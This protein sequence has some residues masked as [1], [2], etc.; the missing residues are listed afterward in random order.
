MDI[1]LNNIQQDINKMIR[2]RTVEEVEKIRKNAKEKVDSKLKE[3]GEQ[4]KPKFSYISVLSD[5][6]TKYDKDKDK[7][8]IIQKLKE[9]LPELPIEKIKARYKPAVIYI[10]EKGKQ[11]GTTTG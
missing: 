10:L 3:I 5:L 8:L 4:K 1:N 2:D 7:E 6:M 11:N 9:V